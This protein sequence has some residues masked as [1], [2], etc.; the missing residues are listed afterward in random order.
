MSDA[1]EISGTSDADMH[2]FRAM[3]DNISRMAQS[4]NFLCKAWMEI[5]EQ[6]QSEKRSGGKRTPDSLDVQKIYSAKKQKITG[7]VTD[8][9]PFAKKKKFAD[10]ISDSEEESDIE[11]YD[12]EGKISG[13]SSD[14]EDSDVD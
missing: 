10:H 7:K 8:S 3:Q 12:T 14:A 6:K 9:P 13:N 1:D 11:E 5:A 4:M 2:A